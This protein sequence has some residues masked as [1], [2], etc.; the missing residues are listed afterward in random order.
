MRR[1]AVIGL[2]SFGYEVARALFEEKNEVVG[3]DRSQERVQAVETF[4]TSAILL[5]AT[6]SDRLKNI[7]LEEMDAVIVSTGS[8]ISTSILICYHL[9]T[10]GVKQI[11]VKA[12]DDNHGKILMQLGAARIIRPGRDM[13]ER[14]ARRLTHPNIL[15][16][17][18]LEEDYSLIQVDPPTSMIGKSL[19]QLQLRKKYGVYVIAV[20]ELVPERFVVVPPADFVIKNSDILILI[21][22]TKDIARIKELK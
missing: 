19:L 16:F 9:K 6:D 11:I 20:R 8:Q 14:L 1:Y 17:L 7:G 12:E 21:G 18:P 22:K 15:E 2:G 10:M 5:D 13:A 3:I 4:S